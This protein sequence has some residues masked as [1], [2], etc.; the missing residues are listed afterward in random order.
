MISTARCVRPLICPICDFPL[1]LTG[2][3]LACVNRHSFDIARE[4]YVNLLTGRKRPKILGDDKVMLQ[5]RRRFLENGRYAALSNIINQTVLT[6]LEEKRG[7]ETAVLDIGCGEG[8][9]LGQLQP[10][11]PAAAC[12]FG[13]DAAKDAARLA[14]RRHPAARFIV[15]DV[16]RKVPFAN[17]SVSVLLNIFAP[18]NPAEFARI[19][20]PDALLLIVIPQPGH[21][22]AL[23]EAF[24]LLD[25]ESEKKQRVI[26]RLDGRFT[27]QHSQP[28]TLKLDLTQPDLIDLALMTPNYWHL[29]PQKQAQLQ[30]LPHFQTAARF[31]ILTFVKDE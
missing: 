17:G 14:S 15:A 3:A 30:A 8:H 21:L 22:R 19:A 16:N 27:L 31:E 24:G 26:E 1:E 6:H 13:L 5:A 18:R 20:A 29:M 25:I 2:R 23:R 10:R 12:A 4:G 7:E 11:L 28:L 9:Y